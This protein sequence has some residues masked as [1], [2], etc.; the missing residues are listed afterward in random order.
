MNMYFQL[1]EWKINDNKVVTLLSDEMSMPYTR[2]Q[3]IDF[4]RAGLN[5]YSNVSDDEINKAREDFLRK[6]KML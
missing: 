1:S 5:I 2:E 4:I 6:Y 3:F